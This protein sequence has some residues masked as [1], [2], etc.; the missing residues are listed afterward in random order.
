MHKIAAAAAAAVVVVVVAKV[1]VVVVLE[2]IAIAAAIAIRSVSTH[3][4]YVQGACEGS[5][6][7]PEY[8]RRPEVQGE[9][10]CGCVGPRYVRMDR[11]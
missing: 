11:G 6:C 7:G 3:L 4:E 5:D 1:V 9:D 8:P 10:V 2:A